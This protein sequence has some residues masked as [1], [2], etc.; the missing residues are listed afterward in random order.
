EAT[1]AG[2]AAQ[3]HGSAEVRHRPPD[4][5]GAA[6]HRLLFGFYAARSGGRDRDRH[7]GGRRPSPQSAA[8]DEA[9]R[10]TRGR[11][12]RNRYA[13]QPR[14]GRAGLTAVLTKVLL[15]GGSFLLPCA[16]V[17]PATAQPFP[18]KPIRIVV[19]SAPAGPADVMARLIGQ[20]LSP[21]LG[22][23]VIIDNR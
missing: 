15:V 17:G 19:G 6:D 16:A 20:R 3:R 10:R 18:S 12:S 11:D 4:L 21:M 7:A 1:D 23:T 2:H 9:G 13:A 14:R 5:F 8:L 22:Q